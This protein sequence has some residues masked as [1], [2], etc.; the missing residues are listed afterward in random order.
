MLRGS[1]SKNIFFWEVWFNMFDFCN[2]HYGPY[3]NI[4]S[5]IAMALDL[6][7]DI[8]PLHYIHTNVLFGRN[9]T[10][11]TGINHYEGGSLKSLEQ[12]A[13]NPVPDCWLE[14]INN[15]QISRK[16]ITD[17][18]LASCIYLTH[19]FHAANIS[20]GLENLSMKLYDDPA[21][22]KT[23]IAWVE[24][25]NCQA[26]ET[27]ISKVMPEL[28]LLDGDCAYKT[29]L[30]V[31]PALYRELICDIT[32]KTVSQ[33]RRLGIPYAFHSDGKADELLPIL[34]EL[35]FC[36]FHGCEKQANDLDHLVCTFG[37][38]ICLIGNMDV[39]FL[40]N[41]SPDDICRETEKMITI[42][43]K[44]GRF[45]TACNTSPLDYIPDQNYMAFCKT[46]KQ[47]KS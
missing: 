33:L 28:V 46:I 36:A 41:A 34:I 17:A 11:S 18:G 30:M 7:M 43:Q 24:D 42:G 5:R 3:D 27:V 22:V 44:K 47:M 9:S 45:I 19:G 31:R 25:R 20:M 6:G 16:K 2:R 39:A 4:E 35:G 23:Y 14:E 15:L 21:F 1:T 13:D 26:I 38:N 37:E 40:K 12:L 29:G 32:N 8:V 10:D